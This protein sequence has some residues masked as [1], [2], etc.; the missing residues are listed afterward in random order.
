MRGSSMVTAILISEVAG[1]PE[2]VNL[3]AELG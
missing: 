3:A 2:I 1:G